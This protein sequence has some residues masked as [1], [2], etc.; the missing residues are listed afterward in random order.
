MTFG[1]LKYWLLLNNNLIDL[2]S[3]FSKIENRRKVLSRFL[4]FLKTCIFQNLKN[5]TVIKYLPDFIIIKSSG[6]GK[7]GLWAEI[8]F[9]RYRESLLSQRNKIEDFFKILKKKNPNFY[10][11]SIFINILLETI[12]IYKDN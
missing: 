9:Q 3:Y 10:I 1:A 5:V 8:M 6:W 7:R 12:L 4:D 2:L 11:R